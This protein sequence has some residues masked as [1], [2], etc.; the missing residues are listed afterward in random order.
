[1]LEANCLKPPLRP[2]SFTFYSV[3]ILDL[4]LSLRFGSRCLYSGPSTSNY[5][6][7]LASPLYELEHR[8]SV[9]SGWMWHWWGRQGLGLKGPVARLRS[10]NLILSPKKDCRFSFLLAEVRQPHWTQVARD[11]SRGVFCCKARRDNKNPDWGSRLRGWQG[12]SQWDRLPLPLPRPH[13]IHFPHCSQSDFHIEIC[14]SS[15]FPTQ[16]PTHLESLLSPLKKITKIFTRCWAMGPLPLPHSPLPSQYYCNSLPLSHDGLPGRPL[17]FQRS[18][19][20]WRTC[21]IPSTSF[22]AHTQDV[23]SA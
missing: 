10:L 14:H 19:V 5:S 6:T 21:L 22:R 2:V 9:K 20:P 1:M 16:H 15:T 18:L 3:N 11:S 7:A 12:G 13:L 23:L 17:I 4:W 8:V